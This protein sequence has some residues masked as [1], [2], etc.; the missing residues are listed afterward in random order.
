MDAFITDHNIDGRVLYPATGYIVIAWRAIATMLQSLPENLAIDFSNITIHR[1]TV[2]DKSSKS[3]Y[4][5]K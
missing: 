4:T 3:H 1:A 5:S 2:I